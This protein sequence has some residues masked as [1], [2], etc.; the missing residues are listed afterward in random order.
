MAHKPTVGIEFLPVGTILLQRSAQDGKLCEALQ[1]LGGVSACM[2]DKEAEGY[3][4]R[5]FSISCDRKPARTISRRQ[6]K[7]G[8]PYYKKHGKTYS[9]KVLGGVFFEYCK[10]CSGLPKLD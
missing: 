10:D 8:E 1:V 7:P 9:N 3:I 5:M 6:P 4:N 2:T